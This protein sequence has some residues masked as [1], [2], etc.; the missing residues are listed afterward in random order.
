MLRFSS[1]KDS[2]PGAVQGFFDNDM[3]VIYVVV[4]LAVLGVSVAKIMS[5]SSKD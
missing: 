2:V 3:A 4:G 1:F 5:L